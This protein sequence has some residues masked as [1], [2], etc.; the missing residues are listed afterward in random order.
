M[1]LF[2]DT[3]NVTEIRTAAEWGIVDGVT[4]NP[5]LVAKE[6]RNFKEVIKEIVSIVNGPVSA[7]VVSTRSEDMIVEAREL[8][9]LNPN[10]YVKVPM[11][12]EGL[13]ATVKLAKE[14]VK[15]NMTLVFSSLQALLAAK[16]GAAVR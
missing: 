7:E 12:T 6:G 11:T 13:K 15:V 14:G 8:A 1:K 4:T 2:L 9:K 5:T 3:A 16:V 10:I